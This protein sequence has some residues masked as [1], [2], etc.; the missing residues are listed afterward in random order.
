MRT[1]I[2]SVLEKA[3][4]ALHSPGGPGDPDEFDHL[5]DRIAVFTAEWNDTPPRD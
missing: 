4:E 2:L 1:R 3:D 5:I